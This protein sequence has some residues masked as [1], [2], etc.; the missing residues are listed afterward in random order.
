MA[1]S[2][3]NPKRVEKDFKKPFSL[4]KFLKNK[5]LPLIRFQSVTSNM[6]WMIKNDQKSDEMEQKGPYQYLRSDSFRSILFHYHPRLSQQ[7]SR[8]FKFCSLYKIFKLGR[9]EIFSIGIEHLLLLSPN[10]LLW[11]FPREQLGN[12][13]K[14]RERNVYWWP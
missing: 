3:K 9:G 1:K 14:H 5:T 6:N 2:S 12:T 7:F 4:N 13:N 8:F 11:P 10:S